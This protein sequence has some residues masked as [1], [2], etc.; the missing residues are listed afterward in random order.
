MEKEDKCKEVGFG[1][2]GGT[3]S[4]T[5]CS[6]TGCNNVVDNTYTDG[7]C[8]DCFAYDEYTKEEE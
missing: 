5:I 1:N 3:G 7:K 8:L 2:R 4:I 6:N